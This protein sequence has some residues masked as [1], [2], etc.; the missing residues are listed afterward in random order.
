MPAPND[1]NDITKFLIKAI[2]TLHLNDPIRTSLGILLGVIISGVLI[3]LSMN[4]ELIFPTIGSQIN[5]PSSSFIF[6]FSVALGV[7]LFNILNKPEKNERIIEINKRAKEFEALIKAGKRAKKLSNSHI[8]QLYKDFSNDLFKNMN[9][10]LSNN[11][12][13]NENDHNSKL[14]NIEENSDDSNKGY[15]EFR[16]FKRA[17]LIH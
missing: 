15:F 8:N 1:K 14:K 11:T 6:I 9:F 2:E 7:F 4:L 16:T 5:V 17:V 3:V 12:D 10:Y 13:N